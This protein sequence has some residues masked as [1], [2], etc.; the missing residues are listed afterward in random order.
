MTRDKDEHEVGYGKPPKSGQ[1]TKGTSGNPKGRPAGTRNFITDVEEVL[2][3]PV[4]VVENGRK[5]KVS[6]QMGT[7]MRLREKAMKGDLPS[8][9]LLLKF[10]QEA[11][12]QRATGRAERSLSTSEDEIIERFVEDTLRNLDPGAATDEEGSDERDTDEQ[13]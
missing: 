9:A 12:M 5:K 8:I 11:G 6:S 2:K 10:A 7:L 4:G 1:F 13:S 3:V